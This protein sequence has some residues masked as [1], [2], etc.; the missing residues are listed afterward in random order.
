[1][2]KQSF[3]H[4]ISRLAEEKDTRNVLHCTD[5]HTAFLIIFS[6]IK[7]IIGKAYTFVPFIF[8]TLPVVFLTVVAE[9]V[10]G[11]I[12]ST[13]DIRKVLYSNYV[14]CYVFIYVAVSQLY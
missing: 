14:D 2:D 5:V 9:N 11:F 12:T 4:L 13:R 6:Q 10:F 7:H 8:K 3:T 1:V